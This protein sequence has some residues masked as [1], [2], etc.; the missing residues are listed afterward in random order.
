MQW[1]QGEARPTG[2]QP[3]LT[4]RLR[5][6]AFTGTECFRANSV[7]VR[8]RQMR[9]CP[10]CAEE[11]QDA[12]VVCKHCHRDL[13]VDANHPNAKPLSRPA[14]SPTSDPSSTKK[15]RMIGVLGLLV[16][17]LIVVFLVSNSSSD[18]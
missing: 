12:A 5:K 17:A 15:R 16:I 18:S 6:C 3:P 4:Q 9:A 2:E 13:P 10:Y 1:Q 14:G 7:A 8:K 11:I